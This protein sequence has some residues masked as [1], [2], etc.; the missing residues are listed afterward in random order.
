MRFSV[1][2]GLLDDEVIRG[3]HDFVGAGGTDFGVGGRELVKEKGS[4]PGI[5]Q[6]ALAVD[7][8]AVFGIEEFDLFGIFAV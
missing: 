8:E 6:F 4:A 2:A 5:D 7:A 1:G 3:P